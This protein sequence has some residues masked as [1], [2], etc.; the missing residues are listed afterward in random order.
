ML[1]TQEAPKPYETKHHNT[2]ADT[3]KRTWYEP[4]RRSSSS[5]PLNA[6][7]WGCMPSVRT[8]R[9]GLGCSTTSRAVPLLGDARRTLPPV[10]WGNG[11][12]EM[13]NRGWVC[14]IRICEAGRDGMGKELKRK[15]R[16]SGR[17]GWG[18][19]GCD[20]RECEGARVMSRARCLE[21]VE[22]KAYPN[23]GST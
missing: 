13:G 10:K 17:G 11:G 18:S 8:G 3:R 22:T 4:R 16:G 20:N 2:H 1:P 6:R 12:C 21:G 15:R 5:L 19:P 14:M 9:A 23:A 7:L